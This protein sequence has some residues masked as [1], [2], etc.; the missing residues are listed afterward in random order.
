MLPFRGIKLWIDYNREHQPRWRAIRDGVIALL[1]SFVVADA[2]TRRRPL[3]READPPH[4]H[5]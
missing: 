1:K 3:Q 4:L 5:G 2:E